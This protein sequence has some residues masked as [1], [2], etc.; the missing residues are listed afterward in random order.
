MFKRRRELKLSNSRQELLKE[1]RLENSKAFLIHPACGCCSQREPIPERIS[2]LEAWAERNPKTLVAHSLRAVILSAP[3]FAEAILTYKPSSFRNLS[4]ASFDQLRLSYLHLGLNILNTHVPRAFSTP[5]FE[6]VQFKIIE[7]VV[8][9]RK[10]S[11][12]KYLTQMSQSAEVCSEKAHFPEEIASGGPGLVFHFHRATPEGAVFDWALLNRLVEKSEPKQHNGFLI[13]PMGFL[14]T[15]TFP[16]RSQVSLQTDDTELTAKL[17]K[18]ATANT[19]LDLVYNSRLSV[20]Q[21]HELTLRQQENR[22]E[23]LLRAK[24]T[25]ERLV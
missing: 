11:A 9:E 14:P 12:F 16:P 3:E 18:L 24:R 15:S 8:F 17:F 25:C 5:S 21:L 4:S 2:Q 7:S 6:K 20:E 13:S 10:S 19:E 1:L 23:E 22:Y